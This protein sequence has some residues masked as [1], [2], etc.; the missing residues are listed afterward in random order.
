MIKEKHTRE[1]DRKTVRQLRVS[2]GAGEHPELGERFTV[3]GTLGNTGIQ[4]VVHIE[5]PRRQLS[6]QAS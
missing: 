2:G 3:V 1:D 4:R 5:T 6:E